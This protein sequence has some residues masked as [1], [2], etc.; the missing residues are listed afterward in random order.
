[1][2]QHFVD[3]D[4]KEEWR[5]Q[6]QQLNE[7]GRDKHLPKESFVFDDRWDK[8]AEVK[9]ATHAWKHRALRDQNQTLCPEFLKLIFAQFP[10]LGFG[11]VLNKDVV[12]DNTSDH[13]KAIIIDFSD[14]WQ[15]RLPQSFPG[16]VEGLGSQP[17]EFRSTEN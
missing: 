4:L 2:H 1:M 13:Y 7:K 8:P 10:G 9:L 5:N 17:E 3:N 11:G 16:G 12:L 14:C 15:W 6:R